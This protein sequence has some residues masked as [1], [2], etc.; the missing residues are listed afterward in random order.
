MPN[1]RHKYNINKRNKFLSGL[2]QIWSTWI[3]LVA[4][5]WMSSGEDKLIL[6]IE[7]QGPSWIGDKC[8]HLCNSLK[9]IFSLPGYNRK[10]Y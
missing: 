2:S 5:G 10:I 8:F 6:N 9:W 3:T 7:P 1:L 4:K